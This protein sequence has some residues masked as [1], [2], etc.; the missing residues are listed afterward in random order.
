MKFYHIYD[1]KQ[2]VYGLW[3]MVTGY[4]EILSILWFNHAIFRFFLCLL[5]NAVS[6]EM[7]N[8]INTEYMKIINF[9]LPNIILVL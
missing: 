1:Y 2:I 5:K 9:N 8:T 4:I 3:A 6:F 7:L